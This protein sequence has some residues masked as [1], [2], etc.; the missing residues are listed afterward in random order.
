VNPIHASRLRRE[1]KHTLRQRQLRAHVIALACS[2]LLAMSLSPVHGEPPPPPSPRDELRAAEFLEEA[3][4]ARNAG[5][6]ELRK[7]ET[8][9]ADLVAKYPKDAEIK[10][11]QA[12]FFWNEEKHERA[13]EAWLEAEKLD[14][15]NAVVLDHLGGS[16]SAGG[17][18]KKAAG[19]Y[20]RAMESEPGKAVYHFNYA[21]FAYIFRHELIDKEHPDATAV[22]QLAL[23]HFAEASKLEPLNVEYARA[24]A[25]T[26]YTMPT[27]DWQVALAAWQHLLDISPKKDF[28]L[29]NLARVHMKLGNKPEA[30]ESLS[31]VQGPE[32]DRVK[33]RLK[34]RLE[35]E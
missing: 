21:N 25:E 24:Y 13:V 12:E 14:P 28:A 2:G 17:E 5:P 8:I 9:F 34:E 6:E 10:N 29:L 18:T 26:F 20:A 16:Y 33:A 11:G 31:R 30:R 4:L 19:Y 7:M 35:T 27:P 32:F 22:M 3:L 1:A 23:K 15:R